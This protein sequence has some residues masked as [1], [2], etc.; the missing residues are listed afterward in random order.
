MMPIGSLL[1]GAIATLDLRLP[2]FV[3]GTACTILSI[4]GFGFIQRLSKLTAK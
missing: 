3:G 4:I 2:F 1:G